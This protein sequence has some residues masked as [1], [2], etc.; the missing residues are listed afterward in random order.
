MKTTGAGLAFSNGIVAQRSRGRILYYAERCPDLMQTIKFVGG[1][2]AAHPTDDPFFVDYSLA[3]AFADFRG[4][5]DFSSRGAALAA[6]LADSITPEQVSQFKRLLVKTA[7]EKDT[8]EQMRNRRPDAVGRVIVGYG[9]KVSES[10]GASAFVIAP[11]ELLTKYETFLR[12]HGEAD[13]LIR[14]FPRDFWPVPEEAV[15]FGGE[16][17]RSAVH[18]T[19][20]P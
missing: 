1:L 12:E 20:A 7:G 4:V 2:A 9:R 14:V 15:T 3:N 13:R 16:S 5:D 19:E 8:L 18:E 10:P 17:A 11:E 6:D